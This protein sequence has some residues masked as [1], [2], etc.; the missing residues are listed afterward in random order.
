M[1]KIK[2]LPFLLLFFFS[3]TAKAQTDLSAKTWFYIDTSLYTKTNLVE[4]GT[5]IDKLKAKAMA[6]QKYFYVVRCLN[7]TMRIAD[8]KTE[9]SLYFKNSSFID[10]MLLQPQQPKQLQYALHLMQASRLK[11]GSLWVWLEP[12][13]RSSAIFRVPQLKITDS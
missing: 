6:E 10:E 1:C 9:D 5:T 11:I 3:V 8:L 13:A 2:N 7:Y 12:G 4:L